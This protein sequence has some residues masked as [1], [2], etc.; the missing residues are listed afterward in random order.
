MTDGLQMRV[1][2]DP[3]GPTLIYLPGLHGDWT[4]V[5]SFRATV[6]GRARFV[7]FTYPRTTTWSLDDYAREIEGRLLAQGIER[8]WLLGES[9]GSQPAWQIVKRAWERRNS[10]E[11]S[12]PGD[13]PVGFRTQGLILSGG[14]VRHPVIWAVRLAGRISSSVP[15]GCVKLFCAIYARYAHF[16]HRHAPE[17]L[18]SI[19]EFVANRT[20]EADRQAIVHRY[21]LISENDLRLVARQTDFPVFYL[22]GLVDPLVPWCHVRWWLRKNCPGYR[23]GKTMWRADHNVLGTAPQKSAELI[24]AWIS[25]ASLPH[26]DFEFTDDGSR[27]AANRFS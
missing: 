15:M 24:M 9:F 2:G 11:A 18:E 17:T 16:R 22:A 20:M 12:K 5:S 26:R 8:G 7:E 27:K 10:S 14:F 4:L 19:A 6:A 13:D 21:T 25:S 23:G 1:H 3:S